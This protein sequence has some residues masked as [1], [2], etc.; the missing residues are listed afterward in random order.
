M[1]LVV[2]AIAVAALGGGCKKDASSSASGGSNG[3]AAAAANVSGDCNGAINHTIDTM[4]AKKK[5]EA[6]SAGMAPERLARLERLRAVL[7]TRC[8]EDKWSAAML[9]CVSAVTRQPELM[10]CMSTNLDAASQQRAMG[11]IASAMM[12]G[13]RPGGGGPMMS[14][15][16]GMA[17]DVAYGKRLSALTEKLAAA[18]AT[19]ASATGDAKAAAQA[20]VDRLTREKEALEKS[21]EQMK[22]M[23]PGPLQGASGS[24]G[25]AD[26]GS[27]H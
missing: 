15:H 21:F 25:S 23:H 19:L 7:G 2:A 26:S 14:M 18:Q 4:I 9:A 13:G 16:P 20:E 8:T 22:A 24:A 6:G 17:I 11:D 5:E 10:Q 3:S 27:A 1:R 12:Q